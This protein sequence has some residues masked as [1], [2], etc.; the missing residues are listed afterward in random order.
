MHSEFCEFWEFNRLHLAKEE[1][2]RQDLE[3][4]GKFNQ[5]PYHLLLSNCLLV[6][7]DTLLAKGLLQGE[8]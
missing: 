5:T 1:R 3:N 8:G 2:G 7:G 4:V 6:S